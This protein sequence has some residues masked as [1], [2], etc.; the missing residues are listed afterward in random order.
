MA[1]RLIVQMTFHCFHKLRAMLSGYFYTLL[2]IDDNI[3]LSVFSHL[4]CLAGA[5]YDDFVEVG[6]GRC[7][8]SIVMSPDPNKDEAASSTAGF[9][10]T[11]LRFFSTS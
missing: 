7:T 3:V 5:E 2:S 9:F 4:D 6:L 11:L 8:G 10:S 1:V